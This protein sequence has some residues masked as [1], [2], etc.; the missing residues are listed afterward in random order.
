MQFAV[1]FKFQGKT[2]HVVVDAEDALIA[3]QRRR[4]RIATLNEAQPHR[5]RRAIC[6][7]LPFLRF[8]HGSAGENG[9][10]S[11]SWAKCV[12]KNHDLQR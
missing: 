10:A 4:P 9:V 2:E 5:H 12:R 8:C 11:R 3:A 7:T 1:G 6:P